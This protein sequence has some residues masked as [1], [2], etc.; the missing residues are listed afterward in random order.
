ML[1]ETYCKNCGYIEEAF[2]DHDDNG[3]PICPQ[4][5]IKMR[6]ACSCGAFVLKG[7]GWAKDNYSSK[8]KKVAS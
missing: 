7:S 1:F 5:N 3:M 4:C 2:L 8:K 6:K